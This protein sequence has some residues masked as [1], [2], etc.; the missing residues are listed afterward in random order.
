V[1]FGRKNLKG[2]FL[3]QEGTGDAERMATVKPLLGENPKIDG[4]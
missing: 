3:S 4:S 1:T 2:N